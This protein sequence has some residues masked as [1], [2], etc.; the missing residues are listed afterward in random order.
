MM[1]RCLVIAVLAL[2]AATWNATAEESTTEKLERFMEA[3][4]DDGFVGAVL[5]A[6]DGEVLLR[7]GYGPIVP[8]QERAV[9]PETIFTTGSI[10]K[11][12]TAAAIL[13]LE[14]ARELSVS[15]PIHLYFADVPADKQ[16]ITIHHLLS[17]QAGLP[18]ALGPDRERIG[19]DAL[20]R[21]ALDEDLLFEPGTAY[22]Y[23]NV[24]F[25]LA[26]AIVELVSGKPYEQYLRETFFD[27]LG[28][29]RTGYVLPDWNESDFAHGRTSDGGDWGTMMQ[30]LEGGP[31]WNLLGNGGIQSTVDDMERW[32]RALQGA[33]VLS[34]ES[35]KKMY[36][37]HADEG[38]GTW[39]G[40][41]WS[42]EPTPWGE[43]ITHNGGNPYFF[44]DYLRFPEEDVVIYYT[45]AS[46]DRR[47]NRL[48]RSLAR[49]VFTGEVP[50]LEP[51]EGPMIAAESGV[52]AA[53]GSPAAIWGFPG[54]F[55]GNRAAEF[56]EELVR[57][58]E[59]SRRAWISSAMSPALVERN[60]VARLLEVLDS[61]R[62]EMGQFEVEG[63]RQVGAYGVAI[64]V[65]RAEEPG[66]PMS[67]ILRLEES[68]PHRITSI[69]VEIGD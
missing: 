29:S 53:E 51:R 5:V 27:P 34:A 25:S 32:H 67:V 42:I 11:Q 21:R 4:A 10:T 48:A 13:K 39:Y 49:I 45:N 28:M 7:G 69:E 54:S 43:M 55:R 64:V 9:R 6:R 44:A 56:L 35:K 66:M 8:G 30:L 31:G 65:R 20:V 3:A 16:G 40:Y 68:E 18:P 50:A 37:R 60:G 15:D 47:H 17:H 57:G 41:G 14:E 36:A 19:R 62:D 1:K 26:A 23:S 58:T 12:F 63:V 24:G 2:L 52:G 22:E 59:E 46:G 61:L 38:G 33:E